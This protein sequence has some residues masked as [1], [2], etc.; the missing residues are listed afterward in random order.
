MQFHET[1]YTK[2]LVIAQNS[3]VVGYSQGNAPNNVDS[4]YRNA[5]GVIAARTDRL[6]FSNIAFFNFGSTMTPLQSC[7]QCDTYKNWVNGA[8]TT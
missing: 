2:E 4:E 7:S 8:V 3:L 6:K 5:R 1:N